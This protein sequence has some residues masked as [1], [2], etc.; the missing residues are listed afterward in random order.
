MHKGYNVF[1]ETML[2]VWSEK[3]EVIEKRILMSPEFGGPFE[4]LS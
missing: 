3:D 1:V 4:F 2:S